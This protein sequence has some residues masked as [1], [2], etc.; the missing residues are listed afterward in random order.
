MEKNAESK[1][2]ISNISKDESCKSTN[3]KNHKLNKTHVE[4]TKKINVKDN[5][6]KIIE[7]TN[8]VVKK[9]KKQIQPLRSEN[10][11]K[12]SK[13]GLN[14]QEVGAESV[15]D[16]ITNEVKS[17]N[18]DEPKLKHVEAGRVLR[19]SQTSSTKTSELAEN[20][21]AQLR[22]RTLRST[23]DA[24]N[25]RARKRLP[26]T[27]EVTNESI[28]SDSDSGKLRSARETK[29]RKFSR[30][31]RGDVVREDQ[32]L[33]PETLF[34]CR[35]AG[36][37]RENLLHHLD[38]KL[39]SEEE[40][41]V[42]VRNNKNAAMSDSTMQDDKHH[43]HHNHHKIPWE[44][45]NFPKNY[46]GKC[47][48]GSVCLASYIKDLSHLDISTQLTMRQNFQR[49]STAPANSCV[50]SKPVVLREDDI[51]GFSRGLSL[52][53]KLSMEQPRRRSLRSAA[54]KGPCGLLFTDLWDL[55]DHKYN[56]HPNV[57]CTHY[58]FELAT[59][60]QSNDH[61][62]MSTRDLCRRFLLV[63]DSV[64]TVPLPSLSSEVKCTKC[65][66]GFSA[67]PE[68]HRHIL[69][70]GGDTTWMLLPSPS[71][72]GRRSRNGVHSA[73]GD[74]GSKVVTA[75]HTADV[76][77][78]ATQATT[79]RVI[80]F[81]EDEIKTRSQATIH[82]VSGVVNTVPHRV[83]QSD[84]ARKL[85]RKAV[86]GQIVR[87][88][89]RSKSAPSTK[90]EEVAVRSPSPVVNIPPVQDSTP[91]ADV[92]E[93]TKPPEVSRSRSRKKSV[94]EAPK[95]AVDEFD[96]DISNVGNAETSNILAAMRIAMLEGVI[97]EKTPTKKRKPDEPVSVKKKAKLV[98]GNLEE[99]FLRN[100]GYTH[101]DE[102]SSEPIICKG[103]G[104]QFDNGSA[105]VR[106]RKTC[107]YL[108]T[109]EESNEMSPSDKIK[110]HNLTDGSDKVV[111]RSISASPVRNRKKKLEKKE[112]LNDK[113]RSSSLGNVDDK[114]RRVIKR[115]NTLKQKEVNISPIASDIDDKMPELQKEEPLQTP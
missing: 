70:C 57:W 32:H 68:L 40:D 115:K 90:Q 53:A 95:P 64:D 104:K 25:A 54:S 101:P 113:K 92:P 5:N 2:E 56:Q 80:Q 107:I 34:Y 42:M 67:L 49:L 103:C 22:A 39:E 73:A 85:S 36:N 83:L 17:T 111:V 84:H 48:E 18:A 28:I 59:L 60:E 91:K 74:A 81:S 3:K 23:S 61:S 1:S 47:K 94:V 41:P 69:E 82:S 71:T 78:P 79:R 87:K 10:E 6:N 96:V 15:A 109:G 31:I 63:R 37:I 7:G 114:K 65:E 26:R 44:K 72:S 11:T 99:Q 29:L 62:K 27:E 52:N 100:K 33:D 8:P 4:K 46:D 45:F 102:V 86:R 106:H 55:E 75:A 51:V 77:K 89:V 97:T 43:H 20:V 35:I 93:V 98:Q 58:E 112:E 105:E 21:N 13:L 108:Q 9:K 38:G 14:K 12:K 76:G 24:D 30:R 66:R 16:G 88:V 19:S 110:K 50:E